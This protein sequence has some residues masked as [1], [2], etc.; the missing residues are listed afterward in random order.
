MSLGVLQ[1]LRHVERGDFRCI[2]VG[3]QWSLAV[4]Q[5]QLRWRVEHRL[6]VPAGN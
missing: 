5:P 6:D 1:G 2:R 4:R 3:A